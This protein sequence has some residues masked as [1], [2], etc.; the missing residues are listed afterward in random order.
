[1]LGVKVTVVAVPSVS[2]VP[3][4]LL[5]VRPPNRVV[6]EASTTDNKIPVP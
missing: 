1:M 3:V 2:P 6:P 5:T 4:M